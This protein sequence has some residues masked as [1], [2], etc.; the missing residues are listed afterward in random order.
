MLAPLSNRCFLLAAHL[1]FTFFCDV[2]LDKSEATTLC[3]CMLRACAMISSIAMSMRVM[4]TK[5][6]GR[7]LAPARTLVV[8]YCN[9]GGRNNGTEA[10]LW[11]PGRCLPHYGHSECPPVMS[12]A[13]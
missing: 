11:L 13:T 7:V 12:R 8:S 6:N 5:C 2:A 9:I 4:C 1:Q 10:V 3:S